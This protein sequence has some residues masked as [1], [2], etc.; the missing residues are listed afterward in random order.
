MRRWRS[1]VHSLVFLEILSAAVEIQMQILSLHWR[2]SASCLVSTYA[3]HSYNNARGEQPL[4]FQ[5]H[6]EKKETPPV[7]LA[8]KLAF[9]AETVS[10]VRSTAHTVPTLASALRTAFK[11][12]GSAPFFNHLVYFRQLGGI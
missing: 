6:E 12:H 8:Q 9:L 2:E 11:L 4:S 5:N 7:V 1:R 10:L 3:G